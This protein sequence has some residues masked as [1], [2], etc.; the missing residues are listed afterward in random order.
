[1]RS[2]TQRILPPALRRG[3]TIGIVA[4]AS[5]IKREELEAGCR[6][7]ERMGYRPLFLDSIFQQDLYFAGSVQRRS[8]ELHEMF[9]RDDVRAI[10]CARGGYGAN[11]LLPH[12][13]LGLVRSHPKIFAGYSDATCLLT[14]LRDAAGLVTFHAPMAAKDF[15]HPDGIDERSWNAALTSV[16]PWQLGPES[17][18]SGLAPGDG[19][20]WLT[21]GC[22]SIIAASLGTPYEI[23]TEGA[24]L[25]LE[26]IAAKPYQVDRMLMQLKLA[27]KLH[28]VHGIIFGQMLDC[29]QP[30]GQNY[31]LQQVVTRVLSELNVPIAFGLRSGHVS[32]ANVTLPFGVRARMEVRSDAAQLQV[33]EPAVAAAPGSLTPRG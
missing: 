24:I 12:L 30:S 21:G 14:Y 22:L 17:G 20:G 32:N 18:L 31:A 13:D 3:D 1:M 7:L 16:E 9:R 5:N 26:D 10:L 29:I 19:E 8:S 25:F 33:L 11:Y 2:P 28:S 6:S 23:N 15:A 4:P 27:G